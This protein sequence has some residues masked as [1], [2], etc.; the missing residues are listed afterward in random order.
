MRRAPRAVT[1]CYNI[2]VNKDIHG[3]VKTGAICLAVMVAVPVGYRV[4]VANAPPSTR[5]AQEY[6]DAKLLEQER[7]MLFTPA[8]EWSDVQRVNEPEIYRWLER[9]AGEVHPWTD[10]AREIERSP[11]S[12]VDRWFETIRAVGMQIE[13]CRRGIARQ[14]ADAEETVRAEQRRHDFTSA[15]LEELNRRVAGCSFPLTVEVGELVEKSL[16]LGVVVRREARRPL[17][18]ADSA[19]YE[20]HVGDMQRVLRLSASQVRVARKDLEAL[21]VEAREAE[22]LMKENARIR[23]MCREAALEPSRLAGLAA[24]GGEH[25]VHVLKSR[26]VQKYAGET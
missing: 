20:D 12:Y 14:T 26:M 19:A 22:A 17:V 1:L 5:S 9:H 18:F 4:W 10:A 8:A 3:F 6:L 13:A 16:P 21:A 7:K 23:R 25:I 24:A 11:E 2:S 15:E